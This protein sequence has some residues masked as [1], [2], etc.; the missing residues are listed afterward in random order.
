MGASAPTREGDIQCM[1]SFSLKSVDAL[2][3]NII[4]LERA[5]TLEDF[6]WHPVSLGPTKS[7]SFLLHTRGAYPLRRLLSSGFSSLEQS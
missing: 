3:S 4:F 2:Q 6:P 5:V 1:D 7:F